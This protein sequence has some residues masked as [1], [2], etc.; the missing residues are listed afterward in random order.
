LIDEATSRSVAWSTVWGRAHLTDPGPEEE[1][2]PSAWHLKHRSHA[3]WSPGGTGIH[4]RASC[5]QFLDYLRPGTRASIAW[6]VDGEQGDEMAG[7]LVTLPRGVPDSLRVLDGTARFLMLTVGAPS[8][9]F[10][11]E[12]GEA[13]AAGPTLERLVEIAGRHGVKPAFDLGEG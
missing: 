9:G 12:V 5:G 1:A 8:V 10:L 6:R 3:P 4:R 7:T 11:L 2:V 13:Y